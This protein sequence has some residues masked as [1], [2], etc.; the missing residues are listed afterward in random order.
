MNS[1]YTIYE[2]ERTRTV[3]EQREVDRRAGELAASFSRRWRA[4]TRALRYHGRGFAAA[5][6]ARQTA[7]SC[8]VRSNS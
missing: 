3:T 4:F 7:E 5:P 6:V 8:A 1:W 2:A